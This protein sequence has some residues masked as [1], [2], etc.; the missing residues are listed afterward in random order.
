MVP[1]DVAG[2]GEETTGATAQAALATLVDFLPPKERAELVR[3]F[4]R[5]LVKRAQA[6][7][8][9]LPDWVEELGEP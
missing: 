1:A 2:A 5:A 4:R 6:A 7:R 8:V 9:P 3:E